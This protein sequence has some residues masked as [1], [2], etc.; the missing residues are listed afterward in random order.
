MKK[1]S[2]KFFKIGPRLVEKVYISSAHTAVKE[3]RGAPLLNKAL[4]TLLDVFYMMFV[5]FVQLTLQIHV[6]QACIILTIM[7]E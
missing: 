5:L 3:F 4:S 7:R 2:K 6:V 1:Y